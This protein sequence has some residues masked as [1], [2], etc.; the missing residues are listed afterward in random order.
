MKDRKK[1]DRPVKCDEKGGGQDQSNERDKLGLN[2]ELD[3]LGQNDEPD[4]PVKDEEPDKPNRSVESDKPVKEDCK[5]MGIV[6]AEART[7]AAIEVVVENKPTIR[8]AVTVRS[9]NG[10]EYGVVM[11][12]K[13]QAPILRKKVKIK[14]DVLLS[15]A[16][17]PFERQF[18][19]R[20]RAK[21]MSDSEIKEWMQEL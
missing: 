19:L 2:G 6:Q 16:L 15:N 4:V 13:K 14:R 5:N 21:G 9:V 3:K 10:V 18:I 8:K 11:Q 20:C 1:M 7:G 17:S 12:P